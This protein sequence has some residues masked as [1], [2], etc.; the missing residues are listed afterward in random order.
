[1]TLYKNVDIKDLES[2]LSNGLI[3]LDE[4]G[5][6]NWDDKKRA[7]NNTNVVYLFK[8]NVK[9]DSFPQYGVALIECE[10]E[11]TLN[12]FELNDCNIGLYEEFVTDKVEVSEIKAILIPEIFKSRIDL[13]EEITN[14][15]TWCGMTAD[16]YD[17]NDELVS[18]DRE[19]LE[20]FA[21]TAELDTTCF[22]YFR[23]VKANR[24]M[25]DLYN[26]KYVF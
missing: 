3:S 8:P 12:E 2:I 17:N 19:V 1:M 24:T 7:N 4:S 14:R 10:A 20:T 9:G 13:P 16:Y 5:N 21:N 25:I 11:A 18:A 23:G 26:V 15:I 6:N 22:N